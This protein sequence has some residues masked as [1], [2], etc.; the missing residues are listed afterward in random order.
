MLHILLLILKILGI[1]IAAVLGIL[2]LLISIVLFVPIRYE[3][4]AK[5]DGTVETL[6]SKGAATWI[7]HLFRVDFYFKDKKLKWKLRMAWL[8]KSNQ[9]SNK[10]R[11]EGKPNEEAKESEAVEE[12]VE[13]TQKNVQQ[14]KSKNHGEKDKSTDGK[15][16][17]KISGT[18]EKCKTEKETLHQKIEKFIDKIKCTFRNICDK[19][20]EI[21]EK[22]EKV[23][24]FLKDKSH[25]VAYQKTKKVL[26]K[27]LKRIRPK[28]T[29]V[30]V[31]FGFEDPYVTGQVLAG[32]SMFYP[33][34][35]GITE[36][37]PDFENKV[38]K[39]TVNLKGKLRLW[40]IAYAVLKLWIC[41]AVRVTYEDIKNFKL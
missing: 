8:K 12:K 41:K 2:V 40:H 36:I 7:L 1:I 32:L 3:V 10:K 29:E 22:K 37:Y 21:L 23:S 27:M 35:G 16:S 14:E 39:G 19:I 38:L 26:F 34:I 11:K 17:D 28:K 9:V 6:K 4:K 13:E 30:K 18:E 20:K 24:V 25:V 5:C 31:R 33:F 15:T